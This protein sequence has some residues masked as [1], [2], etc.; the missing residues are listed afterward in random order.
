M[1]HGESAVQKAEQAA[2]VLFGGDIAGLDGYG[3]LPT[4]SPMC[5]PA[6]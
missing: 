2:S 6:M 3:I 4:F 1:V 5:R